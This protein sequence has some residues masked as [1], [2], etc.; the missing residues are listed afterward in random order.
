[1]SK[2]IARTQ[3]HTSLGSDVSIRRKST[4]RTG[5]VG[6]ESVS[7]AGRHQSQ[8]VASHKFLLV[9]HSPLATLTTHS[10]KFDIAVFFEVIY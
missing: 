7:C 6:S 5:V 1:M 9:L 8:A 2:A 4:A 10:L 3:G